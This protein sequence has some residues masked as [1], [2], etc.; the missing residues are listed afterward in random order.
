MKKINFI[1]ILVIISLGVF[2]TSCEKLLDVE[3]NDKIPNENAINSTRDLQLVLNGAYDAIQSGSVLGGNLVIY[4][5]LLADDSKI[6]NENKLNRFGKYEIYNMTSS[7]QITEI[8]SFWGTAYAAINRSNNVIHAID[9]NLVNDPQFDLEKDRLKAEALFIRAL[10]HFELVR[11]FAK[12]YD[13]DNTGNN[14]QLGVPYR[15]QPSLSPDDLRMARNS[16]E[17]VY[18]YIKEDLETS[19]TLFANAGVYT[20]NSL[21][22]YMSAT[23]LLARVCFFSGDYTKAAQNADEVIQSGYY[24]LAEDYSSIFKLSGNSSNPEV[25]FQ[26]VNIVTDNSNSLIDA[27]SRSKNPLFQTTATIYDMYSPNDIRRQMIN[28]YFV[29][30]YVK[31]YDET[32]IDGV[33]QPLNRVYLR[34]AEM[35]LIRAEAN[36]LEGGPGNIIQAYDS[37]NALRQRAFGSSYVPESVALNDLLDSVR[38]ERRRELCFEGDR[39]HNLKRMKQNLREGIS[40]NSDAPIFKIPAE[41]VSGNNLMVQNP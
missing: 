28:K 3:L 14:N 41:E 22:S 2:I 9:N 18:Q 20:S 25:I 21:A 36:L 32:L 23:A 39:Y 5:D 40:W 7:P 24:T 35:H 31:K 19:K 16:V 26:I 38:N 30:Y 6:G 1:K 13:V 34:L 37:Y 10:C 8:A 33:S 15:R 17:E 29:I 12:P 4:A 27:Y 11:F